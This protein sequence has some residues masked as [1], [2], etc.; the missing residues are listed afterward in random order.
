MLLVQLDRKALRAHKE[1]L[2]LGLKVIPAHKVQQDQL[3]QLVRKVPLDSPAHKVHK[4][5]KVVKDLKV[6]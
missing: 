6:L 4:A 3:G 2:L 5:L 1:Q